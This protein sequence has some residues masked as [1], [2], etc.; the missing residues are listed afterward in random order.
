[1]RKNRL[2]KLRLHRETIRA[3]SAHD[4]ESIQGG[5]PTGTMT[6]TSGKLKDC[7]GT[8]NTRHSDCNYG[9]NHGG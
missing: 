3:L 8:Q 7:T 4:I 5:V 1:M 2:S 9:C 6:I